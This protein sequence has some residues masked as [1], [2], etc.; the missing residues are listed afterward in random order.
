MRY[1][2]SADAA[3]DGGADEAGVFGSTMC[4][5]SEPVQPAERCSSKLGQFRAAVAYVT[6]TLSPSRPAAG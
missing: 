3:Y 5:T 4:S 6:R 1:L 2:L